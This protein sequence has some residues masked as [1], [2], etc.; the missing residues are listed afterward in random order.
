M[1][2][3]GSALSIALNYHYVLDCVNAASQ[4]S[5]VTLELL[6]SMQPAIFKSYDSINYLYLLMPVRM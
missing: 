5:E 6:S 4:D 3:E 1:E 2:V